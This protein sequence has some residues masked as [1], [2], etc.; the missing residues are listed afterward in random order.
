VSANSAAGLCVSI[1]S[2][3]SFS[4]S[5]RR[6]SS[7]KTSSVKRT[8]REGKLIRKAHTNQ[9]LRQNKGN[10]ATSGGSGVF[11]SPAPDVSLFC[12]S[13]RT[14]SADGVAAEVQAP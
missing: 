1:I 12:I 3:A 11:L 7:V 9:H 5:L 2:L 10:A 6:N 4:T 14:L 8:E 13:D